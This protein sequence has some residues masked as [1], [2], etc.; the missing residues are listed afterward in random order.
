VIQQLD[1]A[2]ELADQGDLK[3]ALHLCNTVLAKN[4]AHVQAYFLMGLIYMA[5]KDDAHAES[6]FNKAIYLDPE[7]HEALYH[8]ALIME[9][10]GHE[11][12]AKNLRQRIHRIY[13]K[14]Q[15]IED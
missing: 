14:T 9:D 4:A 10:Q 15:K 2:R 13:Q 12:K 3:E 6:S 7:H 5:L 1:K 8:L 11:E